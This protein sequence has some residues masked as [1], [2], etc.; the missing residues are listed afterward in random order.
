MGLGMDLRWM[1]G[2][3]LTPGRRESSLERGLTEW[4]ALDAWPRL[5]WARSAI[6]M[7]PRREF[8]KV[9]EQ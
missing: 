6:L 2:D 5:L 4:L 3:R 9:T 8:A 1:V 7:I